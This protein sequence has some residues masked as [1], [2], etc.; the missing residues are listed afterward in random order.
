MTARA[1]RILQIA[2]C[3]ALTCSLSALADDDDKADDKADDASPA[4]AGAAL[5]I[6][7]QHAVGIVVEHPLATK[8]PERIESVG[9]VLDPTTLVSDMGDMAAAGVAARSAQA[10]VARLQRLYGDGAGASLKVL[11]AAKAEEAKAAAQS[12]LTVARFTQHWGPVTTLPLAE[13]EKFLEAVAQ[14]QS[15]L[16]RA[17]MPG[18][19]SVGSLPETA[20][21]DV[22]G[23]QVS[24]SVLGVTRQADETQSVGL[25]IG[26][27]NAPA[28]LGPGA[29]V[30]VALMMA[31]RSGLLLP[32]DAVLYDEQG[33]YVFKQVTG[34]TNQGK[35]L[36]TRVNVKL[37]LGQGDRWLV[38]GVD[39]DDE[40]VVAGAGVPWSL[41]GAD[42][43]VADND[44]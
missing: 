32:R 40:I 38:D 41:Q 15:L 30:P 20:Q 34:K 1:K 44:D 19:H 31:K 24:G 35:A 37:L 8:I 4:A 17:D 13:R 16:L 7:Q 26:V 39:D 28:G 10:E 23:I 21:L 42:G 12:R 6:E 14:G 3:V 11:E 5:T 29:R 36:Y 43:L 9:L 2:V 33:A 18:R 22:D 27:E 25:L